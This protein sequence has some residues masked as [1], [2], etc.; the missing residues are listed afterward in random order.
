MPVTRHDRLE[1]LKQRTYTVLYYI[2][3]IVYHTM[4][5][6]PGFMY[7]SFG[8]SAKSN[9]EKYLHIDFSGPIVLLRVLIAM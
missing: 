7:F 5:L 8:I 9:P 6:H 3:Y 4:Y 2:Y 1:Q